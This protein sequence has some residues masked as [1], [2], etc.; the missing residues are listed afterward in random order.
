M[1]AIRISIV[2]ALVVFGSVG[3]SRAAHAAPPSG[4]KARNPGVGLPLPSADQTVNIVQWDM[5]PLPVYERSEQMPLTDEDLV[6]LTAAGFDSATLV[7]MLQERRCACDASADGLIKLKK[8]GVAKDVLAAI[9]LHS[10]P[11]NRALA[12]AVTIDLAGVGVA[13]SAPAASGAGVPRSGIL[14]FFIDDGPITRV[15]TANLAELAQRRFS[16]ERTI[17]RGDLLLKK[18]VRRI[19]L[20]DNVPLKKYGTHKVTVVTSAR[21]N[22]TLPSQLNAEE[23]K[24]AQVFTFDYPRSSLSNMCHLFVGFERDALLADVFKQ[25]ES[26]LEC[27]W[28]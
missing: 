5:N 17:D 1:N 28:D 25:S 14:Y 3:A 15:F 24:S 21:P 18:E 9:S 11:P 10:T 26:R 7:K 16:H 12:L 19:Q 23:K 4:S 8:Q 22:L 13:N 20:A 27:E 6:K 2:A